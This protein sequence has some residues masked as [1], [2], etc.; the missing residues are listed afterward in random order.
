MKFDFLDRLFEGLENG[1]KEDINE[2]NIDYTKELLGYIKEAYDEGYEF[3]S[4]YDRLDNSDTYPITQG[5]AF[6][7][8]DENQNLK[9]D[10]CRNDYRRI[11]Y[12]SLNNCKANL[13]NKNDE[14]YWH[15]QI[16]DGDISWKDEDTFCDGFLIDEDLKKLQCLVNVNTGEY[17]YLE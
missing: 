1:K 12:L 4:K 10:F 13:V 11:T 16:T 14:K 5:E 3:K 2:D 8:A 7:I 17:I 15:I 9:T 6:R